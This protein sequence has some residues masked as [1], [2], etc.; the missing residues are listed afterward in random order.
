MDVG[1]AVVDMQVKLFS[2]EILLLYITLLRPSLHVCHL[3][4][5]IDPIIISN[6][7]ALHLCTYFCTLSFLTNVSSLINLNISIVFYSYL[8]ITFLS[9]FQESLSDFYLPPTFLL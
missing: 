5:C 3:N 4:V 8:L 7:V 2:A 9:V 6:S 1:I